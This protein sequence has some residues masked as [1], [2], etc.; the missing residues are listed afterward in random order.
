MFE[1]LTTRLDQVFRNLR[2]VGKISEANI[3]ESMQDIRRVLLDADV[4]VQVAKDFLTTVEA[5][6]MGQEVL[7]AVSPAQLIV[8]I[9]HDELVLLLG[10]K[11]SRLMTSPQTPTVYMVVGLQGSGKTTFCAKLARHLKAKI[12]RAHV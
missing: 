7:K 12:G 5:K 4:N 8:K 6:A 10:E 3:H 2:G 11:E 1:D 9:V